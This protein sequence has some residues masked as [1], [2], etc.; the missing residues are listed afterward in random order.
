MTSSKAERP[1][2]G[3]SM[4]AQTSTEGLKTS[5]GA[6]FWDYVYGELIKAGVNKIGEATR[7]VQQRTKVKQAPKKNRLSVDSYP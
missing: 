7:I 6:V 5:T 2:S 4:Q 3:Q 1:T